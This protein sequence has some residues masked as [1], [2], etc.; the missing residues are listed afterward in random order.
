MTDTRMMG[1]E[2]FEMAIRQEKSDKMSIGKHSLLDR[3]VVN[4][5]KLFTCV[6]SLEHLLASKCIH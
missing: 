3:H 4:D 1:I 2:L 6:P 5:K